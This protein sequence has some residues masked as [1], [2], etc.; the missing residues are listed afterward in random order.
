MREQGKCKLH[1]IVTE[2]SYETDNGVRVKELL[3]C[4]NISQYLMDEM[5]HFDL[6]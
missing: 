1:Q 5:V 3:C 6:L 2:D 4:I